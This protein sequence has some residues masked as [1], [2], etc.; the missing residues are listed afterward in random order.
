MQIS[1]VC[2][3]T[4]QCPSHDDEHKFCE[5]PTICSEASCKYGCKPSP[6]GEPMC[7]CPH[8]QEH[9]GDECV[10]ELVELFSFI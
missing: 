10:G 8:G 9:D 2:D 7:Y 6:S 1:E 4:A 3:H 5:V